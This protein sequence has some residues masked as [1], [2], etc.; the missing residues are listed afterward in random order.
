MR[1]RYLFLA[2]LILTASVVASIVVSV[3]TQAAEPGSKTRHRAVV[4]GPSGEEIS[5]EIYGFSHE[6]VSPRDAASGLPTGKRQHKPVSV[7]K[8]SN[9]ASPKLLGF[10]LRSEELPKVVITSFRRELGGFSIYRKYRLDRAY[11]KSWSV[12]PPDPPSKKS[13]VPEIEEVSFFYEQ[14]TWTYTESGTKETDT[15]ETDKED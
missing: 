5:F 1:H 15:W 8:D 7:I 9:A 2:R 10:M 12:S 13:G 6:V 3:E 4:T 14:V 11:V